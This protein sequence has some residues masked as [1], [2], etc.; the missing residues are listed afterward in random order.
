MPLQKLQV[1]D[2][3]HIIVDTKEVRHISNQSAYFFR[4]GIDRVP[5][6]ISFTGSRIQKRRDDSHG[7]CLTSTIRANEAKQITFFQVQIDIP[8]GVH[9]A[10]LFG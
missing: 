3:L 2:D 1:L 10:I 5:T 7:G 8:N 6:Y 4:L 9:V